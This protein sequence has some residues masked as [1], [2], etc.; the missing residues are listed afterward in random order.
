MNFIR[1][2]LLVTFIFFS[3][4]GCDQVTKEIAVKT[5]STQTQAVSYLNGVIRLQYT[6]N[7][8]GFLGLGHS[9]T[10]SLRFWI[11][12]LFVGII[13][14]ALLIFIL[15]SKHLT[16]PLVIALSLILS[17]GVG[18][19]IDRVF[20]D[21]RVVDFLNVGIGPLR[22]GI[23]NVADMAVICGGIFLFIWGLRHHNEEITQ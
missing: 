23:F 18:N 10:P 2:I 19:L 7:T 6:E 3:C 1:K 9:I 16:M 22:T 20:N 12:R 4:V 17:G 11:F 15:R 14:S 21:G 8:G 5:L 13:L